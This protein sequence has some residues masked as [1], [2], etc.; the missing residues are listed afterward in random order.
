[1]KKYKKINGNKTLYI[2]QK[3]QQQVFKYNTIRYNT[4]SNKKVRQNMPHL[5]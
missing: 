3:K 1:M 2:T 4:L 5:Q